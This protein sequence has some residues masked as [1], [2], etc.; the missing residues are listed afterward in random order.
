METRPLTV[1]MDAGLLRYKS[2]LFISRSVHFKERS[3]RSTE[4]TL[5]RC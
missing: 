1:A 2:A 5:P 4:L 3:A